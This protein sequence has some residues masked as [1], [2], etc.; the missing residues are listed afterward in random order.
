MD[1]FLAIASS[2]AF[3][4]LRSSSRLF[5]FLLL[6]VESLWDESLE[7]VGEGGRAEDPTTVVCFFNSIVIGERFLGG[8]GSTETTI[9]C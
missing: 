1:R 9:V 7:L 3:N 2:T 8:G 4:C 5:D 6:P